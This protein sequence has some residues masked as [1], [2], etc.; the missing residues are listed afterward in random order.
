MLLIPHLKA[1]GFQRKKETIRENK[2]KVP[3]AIITGVILYL[4]EGVVGEK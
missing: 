1:G 3:S 4:S 2:K